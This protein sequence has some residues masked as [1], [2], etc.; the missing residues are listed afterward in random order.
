MVATAHPQ[1]TR[2]A[3]AVLAQGG[4][5]IDAAIAAQAVL[6]LVE[7]QSS[8]LGGGALAMHWD[9]SRQALTSWDGL[10]AAPSRS[11]RGLT[12]DVDGRLLD[13]AASRHGGRSVGVPGALALLTSLHQRHGKL[14]W[15]SLFASAIT[16]AD[17]GFALAPYLHSVLSGPNAARDHL[18]MRGLYFGA[19]GRVLPVGSIVRNPAYAKTL[20]SLASLGAQ[21]W[22]RAGAA[23]DIVAASQRGYR[24]SLM[25]EADVLAY[26]AEPREPLC[27]PFQRW[28]VC[29]MG[30]SSYGGVVVLQMLGMLGM[31]GPLQ[32][33]P[34]QRSH[35]LPSSS[36][37][38][39]DAAFVHAFIEAGRL[40]QADRLL[41]LG[42]PAFVKAPLAALLD[43]AYLQT[44]AAGINI[45]RRAESAQPG[46]PATQLPGVAVP[47]AT[48]SQIA[49][50]DSAGNALSITTTINLNFGSRL[51]VGGYVLNNAMTNF[52]PEPPPGQTRANQIV[53]NQMAANRMAPN[54]RPVTSMAP[55]MVFDERGQPVLVGGS[56]GGG[57]IVDYIAQALIDMLA[58]Q[59][60]PQQALAR[61]HVS[62]AVPG[63]VQLERGTP[64]QGLAKVLTEMGH[65]P[66]VTEMTS[67]LAFI[68]RTPQGWIGAADPRRDG[69]ALGQWP[70]SQAPLH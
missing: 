10:A 22:L 53:A 32:T 47:E 34:I 62:T 1:A 9:A 60:T 16:L 20:R 35:S 65:Q 44:R 27:A 25:T 61:G 19:E 38:F 36:F 66:V 63:T 15:A 12:V 50:A 24:A 67:G 52:S 49:I 68:Q 11:T 21:G 70:P 51:M 48:T 14:P 28:R 23:Q 43:P 59:R 55:T 39:D 40:A 46:V 3:L 2:A 41:H 31:L 45:T 29:V 7:P 58:Q 69:V 54:K 6:G 42:D 56:A 5:A 17:E 30:P 57:Q 37:N 64:V 18:E 33:M 4:A 13:S 8:G 26:Q